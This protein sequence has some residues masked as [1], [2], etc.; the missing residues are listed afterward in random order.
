MKAVVPAPAERP[1]RS[2]FFLY[3]VGSWANQVFDSGIGN[4]AFYVF[5]IGLGV[6][7]FLVGLAQSLARGVD[8]FTDPLAGYLTD[9]LRAKFSLRAFIIL[10]SIVGGLAFALVWLYPLGWSP[11]AYFVWL[12]VC[13]AICSAAWSI[14]SVPRYALGF[15][16]TSLPHER[17]KLMT[18]SALMATAC[19]LGLAWS[20]RMVQ[21]PIFGGA[22]RGARWVG[23]GM[24]AII[25]LFGVL[26]ALWA[27]ERPPPPR[28]A[29][30]PGSGSGNLWRASLRVLKNRPF[31]LL[32]GSVALALAGVIGTYAVAPYLLIYFVCAG[33]QVR[34]A[35]WVGFASTSWIVSGMAFAPLVLWLSRRVG[36]RDTMAVFLG[37]ALLSSLLRWI[38][39][40]PSMPWLALVPFGCFGIG[41]G[42]LAS[43]APSMTAD[44]CD[45]EHLLTGRR[46]AGM[47]SA[48]Y[49]W[50]L[51][52]GMTVGFAIAGLLLDLT[53]FH[54]AN[55]AM[56]TP[57][58]I[59]RMRAIDSIYPAVTLAIAL[60]L[61]RQYPIT[62]A[63]MA[64]VRSALEKQALPAT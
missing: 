18:Y 15:E 55:H 31:R 59:T 35:A 27:R 50:T 45:R 47:F 4:L 1:P 24:G 26:S 37:L 63:E 29:A 5:N 60:W 19:N 32:A 43:M 44:V 36:K 33:D 22:L 14:F 16:L 56:P 48:F 46:E 40:Q 9:V 30:A 62:T 54:A 3:G 11:A 42:G 51:K 28:S 25:I 38:C 64:E 39:Y 6:D 10:G 58:M 53:G 23:C 2:Q 52:F 61:L 57:E 17:N 34:G 20:Y 13:F 8:L 12:L 41:I 21:W 7:P 49:S